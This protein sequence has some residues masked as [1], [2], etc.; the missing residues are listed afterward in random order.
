MESPPK[1]RPR[2]R[3]PRSTAPPESARSSLAPTLLLDVEVPRFKGDSAPLAALAAQVRCAVEPLDKANAASRLA[4]QLAHRGIELRESI[5]LA[6]KSLSLHPDPELSL[7]LGRWWVRAGDSVRGAVLMQ[8]GAESLSPAERSSLLLEIAKVHSRAGQIS[9]ARQVLDPLLE[10]SGSDPAAQELLGSFGFWSELPASECARAYQKAAELRVLAGEEGAAFENRLRA[11]EVDPASAEAATKLAAALRKRGRAGAADEILREHLRK[12]SAAHRA[13]HHQRVFYGAFSEGDLARALESAFEAEL[14]VELD[15]ARLTGLLDGQQSAG[16]DFESFLVYLAKDGELGEATLFGTWLLALVDVHRRTWGH[17]RTDELSRLVSERCGAPPLPTLEDPQDEQRL[18]PLRRR[19]GTE[20]AAEER[21]ALREEIARRECAQDRWSDAFE[22]FEPLLTEPQL[23]LAT[24]VLGIVIAGRAR[25]P[26]GRARAL[27]AFGSCLPGR[28]AAVAHAVASEILLAHGRKEEA[29]TA[30][31]A[32]IEADP[33]CERALASQAL[34]ALSAPAEASAPLLER[35]LSVLVTRAAT[36]AVLCDSA[37]EKKTERLA[38]SWAAKGVSLRPGDAKYAARYLRQAV[39]VGDAEKISQALSE[40]LDAALPASELI[41]EYQQVLT[42]LFDRL[43]K[44]KEAALLDE[45]VR[46]F[47][48]RV[49]ARVPELSELALQR[50]TEAGRHELAALLLERKLTLAPP[51]QRAELSLK[52]CE[53]RTLAVQ[54][55]PAARALRRALSFRAQPSL[56]RAQLVQ[57]VGGIEP[58]GMLSKMEVE[59]ELLGSDSRPESQEKARA[60][61]RVG[62]ARWDMAQDS[63]G[64]IQLWL[65]AAEFEP[66]QGLDMFGHFLHVVAGAE[67]AVVH[68]QAAAKDTENPERSGKLM[69]LAAREMLRLNKPEQAFSLAQEALQKAP[70]QTDLLAVVDASA[71]PEQ[72]QELQALY[73]HLSEQSLGNYGQ[74][75]VHYRAARQLEK[76]GLPELALEHACA[77]FEAVP[78]EGVAFVLMARLADSTAGHAALVSALQS[79]ADSSATDAER[80]RWLSKAAALADTESLG[81]R[82]RADILLRAAQMMPERETVEALLDALAH[83]LADEPSARDEMWTRFVK[84]SD[85]LTRRETGPY[86]A[87]LNLTFAAAAITHFEQPDYAL[88]KLEAAIDCDLEVAHYK[89]LLPFANQLAGVVQ[90]AA[91]LVDKVRYAAESQGAPLGRGLAELV[92]RISEL[93]GETDTQ[94]ELLVRAASD[95]PEDAELMS[96]ARS[97]ATRD[98]RQDLLS[99][100]EGLL[101]VSERA[102]LVLERLPSL[103]SEDGLDALLDLDLDSASDKLR[104]RLLRELST[105]QEAVGRAEDAGLSYG[106][107]LELVPGDLEA[108]AG[109]QRDAERRGD[110]EQVARIL[111]QRIEKTES[112][113]EKKSLTLRL[114]TVLETRL[115]RASQAREF[116][117]RLTKQEDD[118]AALRLLA[119]SWERSGAHAEAAQLWRK[120]HPLSLDDEEG[121]EVAFRAASCFLAAGTPRAALPWLSEI[122]QPLLEHRKLGLAI[123]RELKDPAA[124]LDQLIGLA[125]ASREDARQSSQLFLEAAHLALGTSDLKRAHHCA[126][127]AH[128]A[129]PDSAVARF[130]LARLAARLRPIESEQEAEKLQELLEGTA[131]SGGATEREIHAFLS[132]EVVRVTQSPEAA[133]RLLERAIVDQGDKPLLSLALAEVLKDDPARALDLYETA[134]GGDLHGY[135]QEGEVLLK[136]GELARSLGLYDR[137]R[138]LVSAVADDES[139]QQEAAQQLEEI[140]FEQARGARAAREQAEQPEAA[141]QG[142]AAE[143][144]EDSPQSSSKQEA[145]AKRIAEETSEVQR[146]AQQEATQRQEEERAVASMREARR[147]A[148]E[149]REAARIEH[150]LAARAATEQEELAQPSLPGGTRERIASLSPHSVAIGALRPRQSELGSTQAL[151]RSSIQADAASGSSAQAPSADEEQSLESTSRSDEELVA[152]L[153]NGDITAGI[154]LLERLQQHRSRSRDAVVVAQHLAALDPGDASLLG[155][156]VT[157]ANRDG[158]AALA[159]AVRHVLGAYGSGEPVLAPPLSEIHEQGEAA[160]ALL[161]QA[162]SPANEAMALVWEHSCDLYKKDLAY[163]GVSG[164]ERVP[165][166]APTAL[167][168]MYAD[169]SR[170]LGRG[171]TPIFRSQAGEE[172]AMQVA[173]LVP[174]A[175]IVAGD[176]HEPSSELNYHLGAMLTAASPEHALLYG[177]PPDDVAHLLHALSLSFGAGHTG[178]GQRPSP[179]VTRVASYFWETIP[180]RAQRRLSQLCAEPSELALA[181][182]AT[183]SRLALRRAGLIVCGDLPTAIEDACMEAGLEPPEKLSQLAVCAGQSPAVAD[184]LA[185]ALSPEYAEL[186]FR[187]NR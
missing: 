37:N 101:P 81:R 135:R 77:A 138:S 171:R 74:R 147:E 117:E 27:S 87:E 5:A 124:T 105:R 111:S 86:A 32:A 89:R 134:V 34:I 78:A 122:K 57:L 146:L 76:R 61:R 42:A 143:T 154:E 103:S 128:Q 123:A 75:A 179:Q 98:N 38:F 48:A 64:A 178:G 8:S 160:S 186:R 16:I 96:S 183:A 156:L 174:P 26:L 169:A 118:P 59:A 104:V 166:H 100:I 3:R 150:R 49:G 158:N 22:V 58:D 43:S 6:E 73:R 9:K 93:L 35:S 126:E 55:V 30:A 33:T 163:Y 139:V 56:V 17:E 151:P 11:F 115:G 168:Q 167:G 165:L 94:S 129:D 39:L 102:E 85:E 145:L 108:L 72:V 79:A 97:A 172:I 164:I 110:H 7:E 170:L 69:G 162:C 119:D 83:F 40:V 51:K 66:D 31:E 15:P 19:L 106:E 71:K 131:D 176:V 127:Q 14:D 10:G 41:D 65:R 112:D 24:S 149:I 18:R 28:A 142:P 63:P 140:A 175:V 23:S 45:T 20:L 153:E 181:S 62:V 47:F 82:Q 159:L 44:T 52:L 13:A 54:L 157:C 114:A 136:A 161:R 184:L 133:R 137:A 53:Q 99:I 152:L 12:G 46:G 60:L 148:Q 141:K 107:L 95:F 116:L 29:R 1:D 125:E 88:K 121:D 130:L 84:V 113:D 120:M 2:S 92:G 50:A 91:E 185:L 187:A 36:C 155:R 182:V 177:C 68:L 132:A 21:S 80:G 25:R 70:L 109:V 180:A 90:R 173:L 4:R 144:G 67:T